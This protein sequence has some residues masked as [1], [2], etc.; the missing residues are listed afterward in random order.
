MSLFRRIYAIKRLRPVL[1]VLLMGVVFGGAYGANY[2]LG[3]PDVAKVGQCMNDGSAL[4][5]HT[6][7]CDKD[8]AT[9]VIVG[10]VEGEDIDPEKAC[11]AYPETATWLEKRGRGEDY[12]LCLAENQR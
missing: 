4:S 12:V 5:M 2:V 11:A 3:S 7:D 8:K 6:T 10:R 9:W 1:F